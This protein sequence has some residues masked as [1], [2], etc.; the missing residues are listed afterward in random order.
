ML[1]WDGGAASLVVT[2][3]KSGF[4]QGTRG[5][6]SLRH[7]VWAGSSC[8]PPYTHCVVPPL[9]THSLRGESGA[10]SGEYTAKPTDPPP[11]PH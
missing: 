6:L 4:I 11:A 1:F 10:Y 2:N 3:R 7:P 8:A 9:Q 5:Q